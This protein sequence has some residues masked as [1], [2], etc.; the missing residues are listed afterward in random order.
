MKLLHV[1][2]S[3]N[4]ADGGPVEGLLKQAEVTRDE[5]E[6]EVVCLDHPED[7]WITAAPLKVHAL[8]GAGR[9]PSLLRRWRYTPLLVPWLRQNAQNYDAIIVNGLWN[10]AAFGA[11]RVLPDG[12][13][14]Y[15]VFTHGMMDPWF[16]RTYPL[17][18]AA[19]QLFWTIGEG[20]LMSGATSVLFTT[21]EERLL[22]RGQFLDHRYRETVVGYGTSA[23]PHATAQQTDAFRATVPSLDDQPYLL[24]LSRIHE[25]KGCDILIEAFARSRTSSPDVQLV[26]A[27][28]GSPK[29]V[30]TLRDRAA[31]L[32]VE[33]A[34]H[35]TGM[36]HGDAKW[37]AFYN[38][39]A[40]ILP[41]HQE[42]FGVVVAEA[43]ACGIPVLITDKVNIWREIHN[44]KAGLVRPD[45]V[46]GVTDLLLSWASTSP[47][48]RRDMARRGKTLF[49]QA[50]DINEVG[51]AL[52]ETI[53]QKS[54][55][56]TLSAAEPPPPQQALLLKP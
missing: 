22:A 53:R 11:S 25:K 46:K 5:C 1:I 55:P 36:I 9:Y 20:R 23:P 39:E 52:L 45:T 13:T 40:F 47:D 37:G 51:R 30:Q 54:P 10:Y 35:W 24:Y 56:I 16:R 27:G 32:G 18:H 21:E 44:A 33:D 17:K 28:P 38:A 19:K 15:Y 2:A 43:L 50:F 34:I 7:S 42:N 8:G 12:K 31:Q 14:P 41:S 3:M 29:L 4:P 49:C 48:V 26:I 6:C